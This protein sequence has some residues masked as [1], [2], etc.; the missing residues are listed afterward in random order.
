MTVLAIVAAVV[1]VAA[2]LIA[3]W[4]LNEVRGLTPHIAQLV[5]VVRS[6]QLDDR[7]TE[8]AHNARIDALE[9]WRGDLAVG[10]HDQDKPVA[11]PVVKPAP[12]KKAAARKAPAA[13]KGPA[14]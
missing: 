6:Q 7:R 11:F 3:A 9:M 4:A 5:S 13:K 14:R 8:K 12:V 10:L 1:A 2:A